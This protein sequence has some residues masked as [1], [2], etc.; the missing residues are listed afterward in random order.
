MILLVGEDNIINIQKSLIRYFENNGY[1][2]R[3]EIL[4]SGNLT[5]SEVVVE[6]AKLRPDVMIHIIYDN[7]YSNIHN[8]IFVNICHNASN[9]S[10]VLQEEISKNL[11]LNL[12]NGKTYVFTNTHCSNYIIRLK[13]Y[14]TIQLKID[15]RITNYDIFAKAIY[16]SIISKYTIPKFNQNRIHKCAAN[17]N[18]KTTP[19]KNGET[20]IVVPKGTKCMVL[21]QTNNI[22]WKIRVNLYDKYYVGYCAQTYIRLA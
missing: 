10:K 7:N 5:F 12:Q 19:D 17:L 21:E 2:E 3:I 22:Y 13:P 8:N 16:K 18:M 15:S 11:K 9:E 20:I 1:S 6:V 4:D 14:P